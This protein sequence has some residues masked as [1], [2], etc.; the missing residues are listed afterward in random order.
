MPCRYYTVSEEAEMADA[1]RDRLTRLL[2]EAC[3]KI[4]GGSTKKAT[5][6]LKQWWLDHE[7]MDRERLHQERERAVRETAR[8]AALNKLT[9]KERELLRVH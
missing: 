1:E 8:Q 6:E 2:C 4:F 5:S 7:E 9:P 3:D